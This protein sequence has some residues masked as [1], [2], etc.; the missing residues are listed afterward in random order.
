MRNKLSK[1]EHILKLL[2]KKIPFS[3]IHIS[4][5]GVPALIVSYQDEH[6]RIVYFKKKAA[7][8]IYDG[9][10]DREGK[11]VKLFS[12]VLNYLSNK[13]GWEWKSMGLRDGTKPEGVSF[14]IG[15][16]K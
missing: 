16:Q 2:E 10:D 4:S 7:F 8:H 13:F 5:N 11:E 6:I 14:I 15:N 9:W 12:D 1:A 3:R